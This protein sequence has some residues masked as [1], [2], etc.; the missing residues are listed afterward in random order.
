MKELS[1]REL[2]DLVSSGVADGENR[3][4]QMYV[5]YFE[6]SMT[7]VKF[8]FGVSGSILA[9]VGIAF[10]KA[11]VKVELWIVA[12]SVICAIGSATYGMYLF[13]QLRTTSRSYVSSLRL[14]KE[15]QRVGQFLQRYRLSQ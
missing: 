6:R 9:A 13:W 8:I 10:L 2:L 14:F 3:I 15:I 12:L 11:E 7:A 4:H 5:W 1:V